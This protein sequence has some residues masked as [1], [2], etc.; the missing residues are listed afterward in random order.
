MCVCCSLTRA[1]SELRQ[2]DMVAYRVSFRVLTTCC[3]CFILSPLAAAGSSSEL[4]LTQRQWFNA[5]GGGGDD[6]V[7]QVVSGSPLDD[8][9][10]QEMAFIDE[11]DS[12]EL[13]R[14]RQR[15]S[16]AFGRRLRKCPPSVEVA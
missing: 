10:L 8:V 6:V 16:H 3:C 14:R 1:R 15:P 11:E 9:P 13:L 2:A 7:T 4:L 5:D 12:R